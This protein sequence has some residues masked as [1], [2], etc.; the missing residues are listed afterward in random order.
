MGLSLF[1]FETILGKMIVS[2][3]EAFN[4]GLRSLSV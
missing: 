4:L 3:I 1:R 2:E